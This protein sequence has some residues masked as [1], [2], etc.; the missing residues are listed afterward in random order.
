MVRADMGSGVAGRGEHVEGFFRFLAPYYHPTPQSLRGAPGGAAH[1]RIS[2]VRLRPSIPSKAQ[3]GRW[4]VG[5]RKG[6]LF[7]KEHQISPN[8]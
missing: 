8:T 3:L 5:R 7:R 1:S 2:V 6:C 4:T